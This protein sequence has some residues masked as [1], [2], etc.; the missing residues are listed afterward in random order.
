VSAAFFL[1]RGAAIVEAHRC[2]VLK[3]ARLTV[4]Y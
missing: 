1:G 3:F 4:R 2:L